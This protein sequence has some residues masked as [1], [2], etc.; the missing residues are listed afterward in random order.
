MFR[1]LRNRLN[2]QSFDF[3]KRQRIGCL[4]QGA[5]FP[6]PQSNQRIVA[7]ATGNSL[8][9]STTTNSNTSTTTTSSKR[10]RYYKL[11]PSKKTLLYGD[12]SEKYPVIIKSCDKL[13]NKVDL[14]AVSEIKSITR[15]AS[16]PLL[17]DTAVNLSFA[18]FSNDNLPLAEFICSSAAQASEWKDGFSMLLDK[19]ITSKDTAE[20]LHSLTE[21]GVKVK[22]LQIAGDR[23]EVPHGHIDVP[24]VPV[25]LGSGF[26]YTTD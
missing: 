12:F 17:A 16:T 25:G 26:Y 8:S 14:S 4:L 2:K 7:M 3:I 22:L 23:I 21:I 24:P 9:T 15:K 19:G 13:P 6:C 11:S 20:Y 1:N 18:L 10:W 5:W